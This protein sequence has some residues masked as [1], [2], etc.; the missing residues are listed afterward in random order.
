M[1][2]RILPAAEADLEAI[3]DQ[4]VAVAGTR[5]APVQFQADAVSF[6]LAG[7]PDSR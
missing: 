3:G 5:F 4:S 1:T 7:R 6:A 2:V